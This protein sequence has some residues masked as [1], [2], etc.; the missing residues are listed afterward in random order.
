MLFYVRHYFL[1][2]LLTS[3]SY[4]NKLIFAIHIYKVWICDCNSFLKVITP[5]IEPPPSQFLGLQKKTKNIK[6]LKMTR[7]TFFWISDRKLFIPK[8]VVP[9]HKFGSTSYREIHFVQLVRQT[10]NCL[11]YYR[12]KQ[13]LQISVLCVH[14]KENDLISNNESTNLLYQ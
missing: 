4:F 7:V 3:E 14:I 8:N 5:G 1:F 13:P 2:Q 6:I 10:T 11:N 9:F 12:C